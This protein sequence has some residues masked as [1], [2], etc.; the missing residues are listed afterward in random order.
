MFG[1]IIIYVVD[2]KFLTLAAEIA[3][4]TGQFLRVTPVGAAT[5]AIVLDV[6]A[7]ALAGFD[8]IPMGRLTQEVTHNAFQALTVNITQFAICNI[9]IMQA[10]EYVAGDVY[11][12]IDFPAILNEL[13]NLHT[14][15]L[16]YHRPK[17]P[18][19]RLDVDFVCIISYPNIK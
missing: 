18:L 14:F 9:A 10:A 13:A 17:D 7:S 6:T 1:Q 11:A 5:I 15:R 12:D 2:D 3:F 4:Q 19:K 16:G 8:F